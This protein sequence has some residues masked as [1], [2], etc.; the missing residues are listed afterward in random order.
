MKNFYCCVLFLSVLLIS[1]SCGSSRGNY[2]FVWSEAKEVESLV[3]RKYKVSYILLENAPEKGLGG[4][5]KSVMYRNG[6]Y[7]LADG[8]MGRERLVVVDEMG[9]IQSTINRYGRGPQE[10]T[11]MLTWTL[12]NDTILI[13]DNRNQILEYTTDGKY[14]R[15]SKLPIPSI[16]AIATTD[17]GYIV[18]RPKYFADDYSNNYIVHLLDKNF[19]LTQD[20]IADSVNTYHVTFNQQFSETDNSIIFHQQQ[21]ESIYVFDKHKCKYDEYRIDFGGRDSDGKF[22]TK[23]TNAPI[24]FDGKM[25]NYTYINEKAYN[26]SFDMKTGEVC[27]A[28]SGTAPLYSYNF[29]QV[30]ENRI[31]C[32]LNISD[33]ENKLLTNK[34]ELPDECMRH[35]ENEGSILI[36]V[37]C[38]K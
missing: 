38:E 21:T 32:W 36:V 1:V 14:I 22:A 8:P 29:A 15:T 19:N 23:L 35:L 30:D 12:R 24:M 4:D 27:Y 28:K 16:H 10:Y 33:Y 13:A 25:Y 18:H 37:E 31:V 7:Y 34:P 2:D 20:L 11:M 5:I 9:K 6:H 26:C 17:Y 3:D